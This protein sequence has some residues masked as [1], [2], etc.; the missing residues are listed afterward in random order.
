MYAMGVVLGEVLCGTRFCCPQDM[1]CLPGDKDGTDDES[2]STCGDNVATSSFKALLGLLLS[3][4][5]SDRPSA[6]ALLLWP[7]FQ[8]QLPLFRCVIC[9][10]EELKHQVSQLTHCH[11]LW[12]VDFLPVPLESESSLCVCCCI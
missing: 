7:L 1:A 11:I 12:D 3:S 10:D 8:E 5:P 6:A 9:M 4:E 2:S